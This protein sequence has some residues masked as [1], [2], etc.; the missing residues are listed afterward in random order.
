MSSESSPVFDRETDAIES[1]PALTTTDSAGE[2]DL[3]AP[4]AKP[5]QV[6][7]SSDD[8]PLASDDELIND[9]L[10]QG[11]NYCQVT[12]RAAED[13]LLRAP[14]DALALTYVT[15]TG[16]FGQIGHLILR[17]QRGVG[18]TCDGR[19]RPCSVRELLESLPYGLKLRPMPT[20]TT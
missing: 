10:R 9:V 20:Q 12:C 2:S 11:L 15:E 4:L 5:A 16:G 14:S 17:N 6:P 18:W 1:L 13:A 8:E 3:A 19:P 7:S